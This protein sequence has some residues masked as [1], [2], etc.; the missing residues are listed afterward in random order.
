MKLKLILSAWL[1]CSLSLQAQTKTPL[2]KDPAV[3]TGKLPNGLTYYIRNNHKPANKVELRLAVKAGSILETDAQQGLAHFMEHMNFNGTSHFQKNDLVSYLQSIGVKFGADLNAYTGFDQTV[4]I[5]P[6]PTDKPGNL[7]K[8]FQII[9]DWAHNALLTDKDID[10]ERGVV[11][12][13]SRLGK[14]ADDRMLAKFFPKLASGSLYSQRLPIG[15]DNILKTFKYDVVR[16]FYKDWYRPNLQA[17]VVVGDIDTTTAKNMVIK[18]FGGLTNPKNEKPRKYIDVQ[19]RK[20]PEAMVVTDKEATSTSLNLIFPYTKKVVDNTIEG[21]RANM[22]RTLALTML[23]Q[24]YADLAQSSTPPFIGAGLA[25]DGLIQNYEA[26]TVFAE[27]DP[28]DMQKAMNAVATEMLKAKQFGFTTNELEIAKKNLLSG[29]ERTY[30]ER[31]TTD[32]RAYVDEYVRVFLDN[33]SFPGIENEYNY[34]TQ[35]LPTILVDDVNREFNKL[36]T[37]TNIFSLVTGPDRADVK[38]PNDK[39][40]LEMSVK[41]FKQQVTKG[42]EKK[43]ASS[44]LTAKPTPGQVVATEQ[45]E[46]MKT[47]TLTLSNGIK[48]TIKPTDFKSD[49]ILLKGVK[50][51]GSCNYGIADRSTVKFATQIMDEMGY[52]DLPPS[53]IEKILA[54]K[55]IEATMSINDISDEINGSASVK[56]FEDMMQ[57]VHAQIM[58]P[59]RDMGLFNAFKEKSMTQ[60]KFAMEQPQTAFFDTTIK[61]IYQNNPLARMVVP[62]EQDYNSINLDR[63]IQIYKDEFGSA[64]G[65][66]FFLIGN[67]TAEAAK[68]ILEMY[69]GSIP[70]ANKNIS[71]KDNGVR[72]MAGKGS[73][74]LKK[75]M[76]KKSFIFIMYSG[77]TSY[78]EDLALKTQGVV[79]V[80]NLKVTEIMR[81]K[82]S[83]I[84]GGGFNGSV[85]K[86]PYSRYSLQL[87]LPCGPEN[88]DK[89]LVAA[90]EIIDNL[91]KNG[92]EAKDMEK[93]KNQWMEKY[94][95]DLK[96]N[97]YWLDKVSAVMFWERDQDRILNFEQ[98]VNKLTAAEVQETAKKLFTNN[99]TFTSVLYPEAN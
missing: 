37:N 93:V 50:K 70:K 82:M 6:I 77:E 89:L 23:N 59:R 96:E 44:L 81:E 73:L 10:E 15:K 90:D 60:V 39:Q 57:L 95:T 25:M 13:E 62:K 35:L 49:E 41:A 19:A 66:H 27:L 31:N 11:L 71:I 97:R 34:Q 78:S 46:A 58:M 83:A 12:E 5:L 30:N 88:V 22:I 54:G 51:G 45:N 28:K 26:L 98:Y 84:Y 48:V 21:Y 1:L 92:P 47:T 40:L 52:A 67:I 79:E 24:R 17:V 85:A 86:D 3:A 76:D 55:A 42:E 64:D 63:A 36:F 56:D 8:G 94:K 69:L 7:E 87:T 4:Y 74:K 91:K 32:S 14:G 9:E 33:E 2:P 61:S 16:S 38:L 29:I 75:G 43:L 99:N 80:L 72:P 53:D 20:A 65:Y 68:P 18:Y